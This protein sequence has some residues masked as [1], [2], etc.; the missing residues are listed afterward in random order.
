MIIV[1]SCRRPPARG[2]RY[3]DGS[4]GATRKRPTGQTRAR[5]PA[6]RLW[7]T[8]D[9]PPAPAPALA[10][11]SALG[12]ILV[13]RRAHQ[14]ADGF[15]GL[16]VQGLLHAALVAGVDAEVDRRSFA[17]PWASDATGSLVSPRM[18]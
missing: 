17:H 12:P 2:A 8:S 4:P 14:H 3:R 13:H 5:A 11:A 10:L 15:G 9:A 6:V 16:P 18:N 7:G 1:G